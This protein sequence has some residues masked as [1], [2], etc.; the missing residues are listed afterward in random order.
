M[1]LSTSVMFLSTSCLRV[2]TL[3]KHLLLLLCKIKV[4]SASDSGP[5]VVKSK[6]TTCHSGVWCDRGA[7]CGG[8]RWSHQVGLFV[9][10]DG[11]VQGVQL[12]GR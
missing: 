2:W 11:V 8:V 3:C 6:R 12:A 7:V 9:H 1:F 5:L 4:K 10:I